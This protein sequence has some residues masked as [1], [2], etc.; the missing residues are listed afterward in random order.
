[1]S[2]TTDATSKIHPDLQGLA[3][4]IAKLRTMP[5]NPRRGDVATIGRLLDRFGQ[6]KPITATP[7]GTVTAGNHTLLAARDELGWTEIAVVWCDDSEVEAKAWSAGDNR[8]NELGTFDAGELDALLRD[9]HGA[10]PD[11]VGLIG[12]DPAALDDLLAEMQ[13]AAPTTIAHANHEDRDYT[14]GSF[15]ESTYGDWLEDYKSKGSR[16]IVLDYPLDE[17]ERVAEL[18]A[19]L[20]ASWGVDSTAVLFKELL[21]RA[22]A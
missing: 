22:A 1:M 20:R 15:E 16:S 4:P 10:Q 14:E 11:L 17:Y 21:E 18:A 7:D 12:Y 19:R 8:A 2:T 6:R 3:V 13:E 5:G 9:I